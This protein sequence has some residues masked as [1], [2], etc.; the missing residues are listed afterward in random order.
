MDTS[1]YQHTET[2]TIAASPEEVYD[3]VSDVT[4]MGEWSPVCKAGEWHD[5]GRTSFTGTNTTPDRTWQTKCRVDVAERGVEFAFTNLGME[6]DAEL[7][8]WGYT[9]R[10]VDGGT[11]VTESWQVLENYDEFLTKLVPGM[12]VAQYLD[13]VKPVTQQG[14]AETL[15]NLK[16]VAE[17]S[18]TGA[19]S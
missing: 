14:M 9:F 8:R 5:D 2:V 6:G 18:S 3:L 12:D 19:A 7:V 10:P 1:K 11:Q 16:S 15:A 13:G 17:G 4:R